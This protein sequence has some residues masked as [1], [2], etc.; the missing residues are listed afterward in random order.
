[1]ED[2]KEAHWQAEDGNRA[3][4][5]APSG[6][7]STSWLFGCANETRVSIKYEVDASGCREAQRKDQSDFW[8][9]PS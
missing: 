6:C 4:V 8:S 2:T 7:P 1:M 9:T 3:R 5:C